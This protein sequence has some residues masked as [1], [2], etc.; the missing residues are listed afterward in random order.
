MVSGLW[1]FSVSPY[2]ARN[3]G[4]KKLLP[5]TTPLKHSPPHHG[6]HT[7]ALLQ[8]IA[9]SLEVEIMRKI[10]TTI[11]RTTS[12]AHTTRE[13]DRDDAQVPQEVQ[14]DSWE[15]MLGHQ[16]LNHW[17]PWLLFILD[18]WE[19]Q[20]QLGSK[21]KEPWGQILAQSCVILDKK[22]SYTWCAVYYA[23]GSTSRHS[24][25]HVHYFWVGDCYLHSC[26]FGLKVY[27]PLKFL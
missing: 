3:L 22:P 9:Q 12:R 2:H 16:A 5:H 10:V 11:G 14:G 15:V 6:T 21:V 26:M 20:E 27:V 1:T 25:N 23:A 17:L 24:T 13:G 19:D 4:S 18:T 7:W 8:P